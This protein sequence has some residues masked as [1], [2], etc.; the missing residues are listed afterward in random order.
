M[1]AAPPRRRTVRPVVLALLLLLPLALAAS[2]RTAE[3]PADRR[4]GDHG[5]AEQRVDH[6][7][8][9]EVGGQTVLV[10]HGTHRERGE[11]L[12]RLAGAE[13]L[14]L[15]RDYGLGLLPPERLGLLRAAAPFVLAWPRWAWDEAEGVVAGLEAAGVPRHVPELGRE[16]DAWDLLLLTAIPDAAALACSS[17]SAWGAATHD[18]PALRGAPVLA[19]NLDFTLPAGSLPALRA[20]QA[21]VVQVPAEPD[22]HPWLSVGM[23]GFLGALSGFDAAGRGAFLNQDL[24]GRTP[25]TRAVGRGAVPTAVALREGLERR[26][27]DGDGATTLADLGAALG[28]AA[29]VGAVLVHAI[30]RDGGSAVVF[31]VD[32]GGVTA[33]APAAG[34]DWLAATN[35]ARDRRPAEVCDRYQRLAAGAA[36]GRGR[37]SAD[38]LAGLLA[39]VAFRTGEVRTLETM[40]YEPRT[41]RIGV[42][43][44][45]GP[46]AGSAHRSRGHAGGAPLVWHELSTL[47]A[48]AAPPVGE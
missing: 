44:L 34:A 39:D 31:E 29:R 15:F 41:G 42:G 45:G 3:R 20:A 6:G 11:A 16:L 18:D 12:G 43:F 2:A 30:G 4:S 38:R 26:D 7:L 24:T 13:L 40:V 5:P 28:A 47:V 17:L 22:E 8:R 27:R 21:V 36:R 10:L 32:A 9:L 19:R 37:L 46:G 1:P 14:A 25:L 48:R 33:R 35:H 23:V